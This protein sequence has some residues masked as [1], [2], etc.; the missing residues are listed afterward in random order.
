M[1]TVIVFATS[2]LLVSKNKPN[3]ISVSVKIEKKV[4]KRFLTKK[5]LGSASKED[6]KIRYG[7]AI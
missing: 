7:N 2:Y 5:L 3:Q 6:L 1:V 4:K